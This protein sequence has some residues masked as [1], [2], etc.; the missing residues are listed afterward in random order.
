MKERPKHGSWLSVRCG[1]WKLSLCYGIGG[2]NIKVDVGDPIGFVVADECPKH[3]ER[4]LTRKM[5]RLLA[6]YA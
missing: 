2:S 1:I 6:S 3:V 4:H 5:F